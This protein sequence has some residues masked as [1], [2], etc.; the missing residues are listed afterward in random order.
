MQGSAVRRTTGGGEVGF[1]SAIL[2]LS[3]R[4]YFQL[5]P[6]DRLCQSLLCK[7]LFFRR[8]EPTHFFG[9]NGR[10]VR[11]PHYS[12]DF[13]GGGCGGG[14]CGGGGCGGGEAFAVASFA[15][16]ASL[17]AP[18]RMA[19]GLGVGCSDSAIFQVYRIGGTGDGPGLGAGSGSRRTGGGGGVGVS[20]IEIQ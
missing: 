17:I 11:F 10:H 1:S 18:L 16:M 8:L 6:T 19:A 5:F 13:F 4:L 3:C 2:F 7:H 12:L 20:G 9:T 14:G 15:R